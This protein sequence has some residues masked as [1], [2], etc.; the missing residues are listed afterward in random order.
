[1]KL[2]NKCIPSDFTENVFKGEAIHTQNP[3]QFMQPSQRLESL[4]N[5]YHALSQITYCRP[6]KSRRQISCI[7]LEGTLVLVEF[8]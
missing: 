7:N 2:H 6:P 8:L 1:M 3:S 4:M 5:F